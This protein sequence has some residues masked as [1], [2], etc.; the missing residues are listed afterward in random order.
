MSCFVCNFLCL[1]GTKKGLG[2]LFGT[3]DT[4]HNNGFEKKMLTRGDE[5]KKF[6]VDSLKV[7]S[8]Q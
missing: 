6:E 5:N 7:H 2:L 8:N 1:D 4:I 3:F